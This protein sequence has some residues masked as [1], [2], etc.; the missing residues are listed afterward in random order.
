MVEA[1]P[2]ELAAGPQG[3]NLNG[4]I[5]NY[6]MYVEDNGQEIGDHVEERKNNHLRLRKKEHIY[7]KG[8]NM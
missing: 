1:N 2:P 5:S 6:V 7:N 8:I 3:M 4:M